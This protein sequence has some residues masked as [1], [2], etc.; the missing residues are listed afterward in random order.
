MNLVTECTLQ[1][2]VQMCMLFIV[3][4]SS[5]LSRWFMMVS[6]TFCDTL[7]FEPDWSPPR[8]LIFHLSLLSTI[9]VGIQPSRN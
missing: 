4:Q 2:P 3:F 5:Q 1:S 8:E 7:S 6:L 9:W